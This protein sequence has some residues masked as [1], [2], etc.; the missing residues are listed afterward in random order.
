M[1]EFR[2]SWCSFEVLLRVLDGHPYQPEQK[3]GH[4]WAG[5]DRIFI[6]SNVD[7]RTWYSHNSIPDQAPLFRRIKHIYHVPDVLY[8]DIVLTDVR[9]TA[10]LYFPIFKVA[11]SAPPAP[12]PSTDTTAMD[13]LKSIPGDSPAIVLDKGKGPAEPKGTPVIVD[14]Y[15]PSQAR[16]DDEDH[17]TGEDT[18]FSQQSGVLIMHSE[19]DSDIFQN[20]TTYQEQL[21]MKNKKQKK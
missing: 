4:V 13:L 19:D 6:T 1:D 17:D 12:A 9:D 3:G 11:A 2:S 8:D 16:G 20:N 14:D 18:D 5:W 10:D 7:P 21:N 15:D